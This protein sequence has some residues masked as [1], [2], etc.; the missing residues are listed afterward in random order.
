MKVELVWALPALESS[1]CAE[2]SALRALDRPRGTWE[3]AGTFRK[4]SV[5]RGDQR[6]SRRLEELHH[7]SCCC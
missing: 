6:N 5:V 1:D 4:I 2:R 7:K 3:K